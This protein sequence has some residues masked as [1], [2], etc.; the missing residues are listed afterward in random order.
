MRSR[1]KGRKAIV[2]TQCTCKW[3]N[4]RKG[5]SAVRS[6]VSVFLSA[7]ENDSP[8]RVERDEDFRLG[9]ISRLQP[10]ASGSRETN[11]GYHL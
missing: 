3:F 9:Q 11:C 8:S 2:C 5:F 10:T 4:K 7:C 6:R 1:V